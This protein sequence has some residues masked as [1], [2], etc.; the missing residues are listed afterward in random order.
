VLQ[1]DTTIVIPPAW[2]GWIDAVGN[3]VLEQKEEK[4]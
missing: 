3:L 4:Y 2:Q 1:Y